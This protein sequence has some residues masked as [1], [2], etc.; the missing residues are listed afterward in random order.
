MSRYSV[1]LVKKLYADVL[2]KTL[3]W[4]YSVMARERTATDLKGKIKRMPVD[5]INKKID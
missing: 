1:H 2:L 4:L 5:N 3:K